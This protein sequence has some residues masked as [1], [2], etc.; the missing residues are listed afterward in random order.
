MTVCFRGE[1]E[2]KVQVAVPG[3]VGWLQISISS[4][5]LQEFKGKDTK[6]SLN[7]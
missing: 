7:V 3:E 2:C 6:H 5:S 1:V 4:M